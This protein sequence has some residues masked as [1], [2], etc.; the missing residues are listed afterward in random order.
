M[1]GAIYGA[2]LK[3]AMAHGGQEPPPEVVSLHVAISVTV[4]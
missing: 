1:V 4:S 3:L 2:K